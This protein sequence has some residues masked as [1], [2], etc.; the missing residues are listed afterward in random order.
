VRNHFQV[1][2]RSDG[3]EQVLA[4]SGEL[5]LAAAS[6]FEAALER[7]LTSDAERIVLDAESLEFIDSTGLSVLVRAQQRAEQSGRQ[8]GLINPSAQVS[9][10]LELTGLADRLMLR[11]NGGSSQD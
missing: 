11:T 6:A 1:E 4:I 2:R 7:A 3:T 8:L 10:L 9:R 5:D